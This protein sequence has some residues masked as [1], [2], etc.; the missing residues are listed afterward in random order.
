MKHTSMGFGGILALMLAACAPDAPPPITAL[1]AP[2]AASIEAHI[3]Y[4][5]S[6]DLEGREAG[7]PGYDLAA[8][9][10]AAEFKEMGLPPAGTDGT[11]FQPISFVRSVRGTDGRKFEVKD[12]D[13]KS[14]PFTEN[15][16]VAINGSLRGAETAAEGQAVFVGFGIVAPDLGRDDYAG[17]DLN[18]KVAVMLSGTPKG[19]QTEERAFYGTRKFK[20]ASDRGAVGVVSLETPTSRG[21]YPFQRLIAEGRL[22]GANLAW[23]QADGSPYSIA[24][25]I[26]ATATVSLEGAAPLFAGTPKSWEEIVA[27]AEAEGGAVT[28]FDLPLTI[29]IAQR[30]TLDSVQSANVIGMIEGTD[31]ELKDEVIVLSAHLDHIGVLKTIEED[32]INNGALDIASGIATMLEAAR[33]L[34]NG[35]PLRRTVLFAAVTAEEKGLLGAQYFA[36]NPTVPAGSIVAN[37]N[38][39]MPILTYD[40]TDVIVFGAT[41]STIAVAV[42]AAAKEMGIALSPDPV[43]DQGLFTRSDHF[44]F[45]EAGIPS[46]YLDPG[47]Q[48]GGDT[49]FAEHMAK[50][51]HRPTDDM[52]NNLN[53]DAGARFADLNARIALALANQDV[54]PLWKKDDFFARQFNGPMEP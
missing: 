25:N 38:L 36:N 4:L 7:T 27:E 18:G 35:P 42:E 12:A 16:N 8:D 39:D 29:S 6:D 15:V 43:P 30:S 51:Y 34:K 14:L 9:Y 28:G 45:V 10:V 26:V 46:V 54:R 2:D 13:G 20:N 19:L 50:N 1:P 33:M 49:A 48:N 11:Y 5:A 23:T 32:T 31:P 24:P 44:R 47:F 17:L 3:A 52:S 37:V 21:V 53:F 40:F 41:R 22:D